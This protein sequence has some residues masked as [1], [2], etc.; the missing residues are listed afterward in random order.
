MLLAMD[1]GGT[2]IRYHLVDTIHNKTILSETKNTS[3]TPL[4]PLIEELI[5]QYSIKKIAIAYAGQVNSGTILSSPNIQ[6]DEPNIA[7]YFAKNFNIP[8]AIENDLKSA[9]LAEYEYWG[10]SGTM[11]VASIGTGFGAAIVE[12]GKLLRGSH[13]LAGEIGHIP[14]RYSEIP[15]GCGNHYCIEASASGK[16]LERWI[17][18]Y[19]LPTSNSP[20]TTLKEANNPQADTILQ[21][22]H[23]GLIYA[24]ATTISLLNPDIIVLGGGVIH[25]NRYLLEM[26]ESQI[27]RYALPASTKETKILLSELKDAPL[28]GSLLLH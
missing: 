19:S 26:I 17:E 9:A 7:D 16:A 24:I 1:V 11:V 8:L 10:C 23:D 20:L 28:R 5:S 6:V 4:I 25:K 22:F 21:N 13:N 3:T 14:F 12:D 27:D 15:C 18:Y 2:N